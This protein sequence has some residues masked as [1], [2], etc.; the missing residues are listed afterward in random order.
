MSFSDE[1]AANF[2]HLNTKGYILIRNGLENVDE[3]EIEFGR[4][5]VETENYTNV[6]KFVEKNVMP[7]VS[8][9]LGFKSPIFGKTHMSDNHN[10]TTFHRDCY[11]LYQTE[12][13]MPKN[14]YSIISN[15]KNLQLFQEYPIRLPYHLPQAL[16]MVI[17]LDSTQFTVIE[18]SHLMTR[19]NIFDA[20]PIYWNNYLKINVNVGDIVIFYSHLIHKGYYYPLSLQ[21]SHRRVIQCFELFPNQEQSDFE[22]RYTAYM[23]IS[24]ETDGISSGSSGGGDITD[25]DDVVKQN[26]LKMERL[27]SLRI[28]LLKI[29]LSV[30]IVAWISQ[31]IF[32]FWMIFNLHEYQLMNLFR[33]NKQRSKKKRMNMGVPDLDKERKPWREY[34]SHNYRTDDKFDE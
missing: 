9:H 4:R 17:F 27:R 18:G 28:L 25:A 15:K 1:I 11:A 12:T 10:P 29:I 24:A 16:T 3:S 2:D 20:L 32:Y 5:G 34:G 26:E 33:N 7:L 30:P 8:Q 23:G 14:L 19:V 22:M 6:F 21:Q 31:M 13:S